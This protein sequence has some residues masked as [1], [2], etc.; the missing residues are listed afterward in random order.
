MAHGSESTLIP[1]DGVKKTEEGS[2]VKSHKFFSI[3]ERTTEGRDIVV[4]INKAVVPDDVPVLSELLRTAT[5]KDSIQLFINCPGGEIY[6]TLQVLNAIEACK[7]KLSVVADGQV[8]SAIA[9]IFLAVKNRKV[10]DNSF[11]F[12]H[13]YSGMT[14]G[15]GNEQRSQVEF[16][17]EFMKNLFR[18]YMSGFLTSE[19]LGSIFEGKDFYFNAEQMRKRLKLLDSPSITPKKTKKN[20]K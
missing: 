17:D 16:H 9:L 15:K 10:L 12:I 14:V 18:K 8:A 4:Y 19:E 20:K 3:I 11:F 6:P 7:A 5:D 1:Y 2:D 13:Y